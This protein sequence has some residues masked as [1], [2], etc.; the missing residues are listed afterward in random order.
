MTS[1]GVTLE[2][3]LWT[4]GIFNRSIYDVFSFDFEQDIYSWG[5]N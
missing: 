2:A 1:Y 5:G 4:L 3:S